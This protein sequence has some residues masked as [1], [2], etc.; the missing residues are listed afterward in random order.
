MILVTWLSALRLLPEK[1][2]M[3]SSRTRT[4]TR[5]TTPHSYLPYTMH[6]LRISRYHWAQ[7]SGRSSDVPILQCSADTDNYQMGRGGASCHCVYCVTRVS[8]STKVF[9]IYP[10][11]CH[12]LL[13]PKCLLGP[14]NFGRVV[15]LGRWGFKV[16]A[17]FHPNITSHALPPA[18]SLQ[19]NL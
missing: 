17:Q 1:M 8:N 9:H 10:C 4:R 14:I 15:Q 5:T 12:V 6:P 3:T 11:L 19:H 18:S 2:K 16:S 7:W 13:K